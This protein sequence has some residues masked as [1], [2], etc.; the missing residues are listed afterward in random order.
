VL[1][2]RL[3]KNRAMKPEERANIMK[4]LKELTEKITQL[5]N[6]MN[7]TPQVS[8]GKTNH[9]QPKTKTDV[10]LETIQHSGIHT[11]KCLHKYFEVFNL[12]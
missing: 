3:E 8:S 12:A 10:S 7:P 6:E 11:F 2:N 5:Q 1:I 4:T 9:S